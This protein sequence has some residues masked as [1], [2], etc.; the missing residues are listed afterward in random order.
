MFEISKDL[1]QSLHFALL[2][3]LGSLPSQHSYCGFNSHPSQNLHLPI[4]TL[5]LVDLCTLIAYYIDTWRSSTRPLTVQSSSVPKEPSRITS[6]ADFFI[7]YSIEYLT[8]GVYLL[9]ATLQNQQYNF[10][11]LYGTWC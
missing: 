10:S 6:L 2:S 11:E 3:H 5:A 1:T 9:N 7:H 8:S 4:V